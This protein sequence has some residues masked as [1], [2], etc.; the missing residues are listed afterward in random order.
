MKKTFQKIRVIQKGIH[1]RKFKKS[2]SLGTRHR[3]LESIEKTSPTRWNRSGHRQQGPFVGKIILAIGKGKT[4][5]MVIRFRV[6]K[7]R[8]R[9]TKSPG[10]AHGVIKISLGA[11]QGQNRRPSERFAAPRGGKALDRVETGDR[12]FLR[13][14]GPRSILWVGEPVADT[15]PKAM[16]GTSGV[17]GGIGRPLAFSLT[18]GKKPAGSIPPEFGRFS[19]VATVFWD[20][21][22]KP[23]SKT[24]K[25]PK[26]N[27][28]LMDPVF[29]H[30][31]IHAGPPPKKTKGGFTPFRGFFFRR[32]RLANGK[33]I[34]GRL[35]VFV[36]AG[37]GLAH[38]WERLK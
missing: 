13:L 24:Q 17:L 14:R 21:L 2:V 36:R 27:L 30:P 4:L 7:K 37:R 1:C 29:S 10:I 16:A 28:P 9:K 18:V 25:P 12:H 20:R 22:E 38:R 23:P 3:D 35:F 32:G 15:A 19:R 31:Q 33:K 26:K 5:W 8:G 34:W 6:C 11:S